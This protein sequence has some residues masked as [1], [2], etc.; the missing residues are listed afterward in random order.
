MRPM[1]TLSGT[2]TQT[3]D[4][5]TDVATAQAHFANPATIAANFGPL[6]PVVS[7]MVAA[8]MKA[9]VTRMIAALD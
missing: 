5:P 2:F 6:Q 3:F 4:L 8:E 1:A 9:Y 7:R